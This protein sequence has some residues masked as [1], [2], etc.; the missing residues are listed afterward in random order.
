MMSAYTLWRREVVRFLRQKNRII[1][2]LATPLVFWWLIGSG[3]GSS[4]QT[5]SA[6]AGTTYLQY[7]FPGTILL[8]VLFTAIFS[9][10]SIIE[11]RREG[12]LQGVLIAPGSRSA[13]VWGKI[14]GGATLATG[15]GLLFSLLGLLLGVSFTFT[16]LGFLLITLFL[17]GMALTALGYLIAW[18]LD[19]T[20]GF[21]ALM[22]LVLMPLWLLSG[23][24][25]PA[26]GAAGWM[27]VCIRLNPLHYGLEALRQNL[28]PGLVT[29]PS[30]GSCYLIL[31]GFTVFLIVICIQ[32]TSRYAGKNP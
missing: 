16:S 25:F 19:S 4:F 6:P 11:D 21:H 8:I 22:N 30:L 13:I 5:S 17:T 23:A 2:A 9:T 10:I 28:V 18:P 14:L 1:G 32:I 29:T 12:F 27:R 3:L 24:L 15:Q 20:Q 26:E 7:F 31:S